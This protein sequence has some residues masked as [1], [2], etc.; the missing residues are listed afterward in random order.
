MVGFFGAIA[1][2]LDRDALRKAVEQSVPAA[3]REL[4]LKAFDRGYEYGLQHVND[5][6]R[7]EPEFAVRNFDGVV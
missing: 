5:K 1:K 7:A 6:L 3:F 2:L 4:N